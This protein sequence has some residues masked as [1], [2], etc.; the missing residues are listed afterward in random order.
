MRK[1]IDHPGEGGETTLI[2]AV[3]FN[4]RINVK[5]VQTKV[6]ESRSKLN[7]N[8]KISQY[9]RS[10]SLDSFLSYLFKNGKLYFFI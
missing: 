10:M 9:I 2:L 1:V 3:I 6:N 5:L 8:N 4:K 7:N